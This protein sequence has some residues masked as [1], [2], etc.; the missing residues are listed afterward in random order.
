MLEKLTP[1][2]ESEKSLVKAE[3]AALKSRLT[4]QQQQ[5]KQAKLPVIILIEGWG[6]AGKGSLISDIILNIDPRS[7]TVR[8]IS[9]PTLEE[10]RRPFLW[11][12]FKEIPEAG[13]F[14]F[15]DSGWYGETIQNVMCD[16]LDGKA[17]R[18]RIDSINAFERQLTDNGYL[19]VKFF[20]HIPKKIQDERFR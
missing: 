13:Q 7:F 3:V 5:I 1:L 17:Y 4:S 12:Y 9:P 18:R 20:I 6:A 8:S 10:S 16:G 11:R 19:V 15:F 2:A 14:L